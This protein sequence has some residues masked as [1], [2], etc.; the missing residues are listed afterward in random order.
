MSP[1][2]IRRFRAERLLRR[3]FDRLRASVLSTV[4]ARLGASG[5]TLDMADLDACYAQAWHGLYTA[6]LDGVEIENPAGWLVVV[7]L[8]RAIEE[9][10]SRH[11]ASRAP[12]V[13][14]E[15]QG[16]EPDIAAQIDD[17]SRLRQVFEGLRE[18]LNEREREAATL[19]Y[20]QGLTRSEAAAQMGVSDRRMRKLMEGDGA[21]G[22]GVSGKV[23]E[24]LAVI[25]ADSWCEQRGSMMRALAMGILD[26]GG[27]RHQLAVAHQREC[28][29][30]RR[31]VLSL[32]GLAAVL[33]PLLPPGWL[34]FSSG[35][36]AGA[37]AGAGVG[38]G[39]GTGAGAAVV[40]GGSAAG[41]SWAP[42][43]GSLGVKLAGGLAALGLAAGGAA[44]VAIPARHSE[45]REAGRRGVQAESAPVN[46]GALGLVPTA[47]GASQAPSAARVGRNRRG[48]GRKL[49]STDAGAAAEQMAAP[50]TEF[51]IEQNA[52]QSVSPALEAVTAS[53]SSP[54]S[55]P[56]GPPQSGAGPAAG[57]GPGTGEF[58]FE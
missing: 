6:V 36:G 17:L 21:G 7:T 42:F 27:E 55:P 41:V 38:A 34:G 10:R 40:S 32:R 9:R 49:P 14:L 56:S 47:T 11:N 57:G 53:N 33:P 23:G 44:V 3:D 12:G 37:G 18:R 25:R 51:G 19:C 50:S 58:S 45:P 46:L 24:L 5:G 22:Q 2:S 48:G 1:L 4:R 52:Q 13:E 35:A 29:A 43:A 30:C 54:V 16:S 31:Y 15:D 39:T 8:R 28:P 20:L 26:P